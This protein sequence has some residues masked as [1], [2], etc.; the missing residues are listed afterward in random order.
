LLT[1]KKRQ[2]RDAWL[3]LLSVACQRWILRILEITVV[4]DRASFAIVA[5]QKIDIELKAWNTIC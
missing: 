4:I 3:A 5:A 2:P 1:Q